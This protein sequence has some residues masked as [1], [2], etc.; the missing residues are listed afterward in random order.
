MDRQ[1]TIIE[2]N[3]LPPLRFG[4]LWRYR[5]LFL[6]LAWRNLVVR[7][8]QTFLGAVW[9]LAQPLA[10]MIAFSVVFGR[11]AGLGGIGGVP[12]PLMVFPGVLVWQFFSA[13]VTGGS[14]R[15]WRTAGF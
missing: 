3:R 11:I 1:P 15:F 14:D 8:K 13:V 7:Y 10:T 9:V 5:E 6:M 12:Y 2:A 4:E